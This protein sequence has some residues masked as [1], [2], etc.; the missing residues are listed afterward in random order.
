MSRKGTH[1]KF[2]RRR[3]MGSKKRRAMKIARMK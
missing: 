2:G 1:T 3:K